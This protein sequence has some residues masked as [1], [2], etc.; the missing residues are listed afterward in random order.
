MENYL[1]PGFRFYP[2]EE[3]LISFYLQKKLEDDGSDDLKQL[4]D[5]IVPI[6]DIY[7]FNPWDLPRI[8]FYYFSPSHLISYYY[9]C[10]H[11]PFFRQ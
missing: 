3:E 1:I 2:T 11:I 8:Y 5:Q 9:M 7:D 4:M 10:V 6:L